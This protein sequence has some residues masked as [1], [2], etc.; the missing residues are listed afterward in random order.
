M[1]QSTKQQYA[2]YN[3][4]HVVTPQGEFRIKDP[5]ATQA[6]FARLE[7]KA[8]QWY[9]ITMISAGVTLGIYLWHLFDAWFFE[10][11]M[12]SW[13]NPQ[14]QLWNSMASEEFWG[15]M[16]G[17]QAIGLR[18]RCVSILLSKKEKMSDILPVNRM[19]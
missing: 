19:M 7:A 14:L 2:S 17:F 15:A 6:E 4:D 1:L 9:Q 18:F 5:A 12:S 8:D 13:E 11:A 3:P 16:C 10:G